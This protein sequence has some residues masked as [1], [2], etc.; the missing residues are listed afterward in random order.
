ML[1]SSSFFLGFNWSATISKISVLSNKDLVDFFW[2]TAALSAVSFA[3][4]LTQKDAAAIAVAKSTI[5]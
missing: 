5:L 4:F 1:G 2:R 3:P